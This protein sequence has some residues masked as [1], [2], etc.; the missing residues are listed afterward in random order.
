MKLEPQQRN[1]SRSLIICS[2]IYPSTHSSIHHRFQYAP[3][4]NQ[5][6][7]QVLRYSFRHI[8][9]LSFF[10]ELSLEL[11]LKNR[12]NFEIELESELKM[13]LPHFKKGFIFFKYINMIFLKMTLNLALY[14]KQVIIAINW[15]YIINI[16]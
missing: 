11:K 1:D 15:L 14:F 2:F 10:L 16:T 9:V 8:E 7:G 5:I 4:S 13:L 12:L 6:K 3:D